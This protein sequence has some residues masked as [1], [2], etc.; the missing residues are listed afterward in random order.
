MVWKVNFNKNETKRSNKW[1]P[2]AKYILMNQHYQVPEKKR[3]K[4]CYN[5]ENKEKIFINMLPN[6]MKCLNSESS[7]VWEWMNLFMSVLLFVYFLPERGQLPG[8]VKWIK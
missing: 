2:T 5:F 4:E 1:K 7:I 8:I 3:N 6:E